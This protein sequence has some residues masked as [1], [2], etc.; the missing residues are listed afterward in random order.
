MQEWYIKFLVNCGSKAIQSSK[1]GGATPQ[2]NELHFIINN[3]L[4]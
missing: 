4:K 2:A 1:E 3:K